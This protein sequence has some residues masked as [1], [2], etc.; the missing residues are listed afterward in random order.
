MA[1]VTKSIKLDVE[2]SE[3]VE[4]VA[5]DEQRSP[6][7]IMKQAIEEYVDRKEKQARFRCDADAAWEHYQRT[8]LHVT[9]EEAD[10]WLSRLAR[11]EKTPRPKSHT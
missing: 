4:R 5:E 3:R 9:F 11:G 7:W 6:H 1:A 10:E 8:G 2:M